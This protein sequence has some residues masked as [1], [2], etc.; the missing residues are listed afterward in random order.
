MTT[1]IFGNCQFDTAQAQLTVGGVVVALEPKPRDLLACLLQA[2]GRVVTHEELLDTVWQTRAISETVVAR[3]IMKLRRALGDARG[4]RP[5]IYTVARQGYRV[6]VHVSSVSANPGSGT[7]PVNYA[8]PGSAYA[9]VVLPVRPAAEALPANDETK[10]Q[11]P[12]ASELSQGGLGLSGLF[13]TLLSELSGQ[14]CAPME[15]ALLVHTESTHKPDLHA[16][17]CAILGAA[18]AISAEFRRVGA[19]LELHARWGAQSASAITET[20]AGGDEAHLLRQLVHRLLG[21]SH[22]ALALSPFANARDEITR[23]A[24][25]HGLSKDFV[26]ALALFKGLAPEAIPAP[27]QTVA[28]QWWVAANDAAGAIAFCDACLTHLALSAAPGES[29]LAHQLGLQLVKAL[30]LT[31]KGDNQS[32]HV[33]LDRIDEQTSP[34]PRW[35]AMRVQALIA[36]SKCLRLNSEDQQALDVA[37]RCVGLAVSSGSALLEA[38]ARIQ[39]FG[40][41]VLLEVI[42]RQ[43]E[44]LARTQAAVERCDLKALN[45]ELAHLAFLACL[46]RRRFADALNAVRL[47]AGSAALANDGLAAERGRLFEFLILVRSHQTQ[48]ALVHPLAT[49]PVEETSVSWRA[50]LLAERTLLALQSSGVEAALAVTQQTLGLPQSLGSRLKRVAHQDR[51]TL[52]TWLGRHEEARA[53]Y[54]ALAALAPTQQNLAL[55]RAN[56]LLGSGKHSEAVQYLLGEWQAHPGRSHAHIDLAISLGWLCLESN[57][58]SLRDTLHAIAGSVLDPDNET[59]LMRLFR[60]AYLLQ[61]APSEHSMD[62][63]RVTI[64]AA[65][66]LRRRAAWLGTEAFAQALA[67][68]E[69]QQHLPVLLIDFC[70]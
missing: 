27:L 7:D 70:G 45:L 24:F 30:A 50:V 52:L 39:S 47:Y 14:P 22:P 56:L 55:A 10:A 58:A 1:Y 4:Q 3:A 53:A 61:T 46:T 67:Q 31:L 2:Q 11:M 34:K 23:L 15:D 41:L 5:V 51:C 33:L 32:A 19:R 28:A 48:L 49:S 12:R 54:D 69:V 18:T 9:Y 40:L 57:D 8:P 36:W 25:S 63:W 43:A 62:F 6:G 38:R 20:F 13:W 59:L 66:V 35:A 65:P 26:S 37:N 21:L 16:H 17:A 64:G 44:A 29:L 60:A 42:E 68:R